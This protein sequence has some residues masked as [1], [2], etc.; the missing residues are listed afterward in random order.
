MELRDNKVKAFVSTNLAGARQAAD[1]S[2]E[3]YRGGAPLS[4][5]DGLPLG[6]KDI[7]ETRDMPTQ[8]GS[9]LF[10]DWQSAG[11]AACITALRE[12][13]A[14]ILGKVVTCEFA[15]AHPSVTTNP[16]DPA[17]TPGGS[18][19][20][21][22]AAV[23]A[24]MVPVA[25]G[26]QALGSITRPA[27]YCGAYGY[28]PSLGAVNRRGCHDHVSQSC[29]GAIGASLADCWTT[30]HAIASRA[31]GAFGHPGLYG[32]E[33]LSPPLRPRRIIR[34]ETAGWQEADPA[35]IDQYEVALER[36][37]ADGIDI[38]GRTNSAPV[39]QFEDL[40]ADAT[41]ITRRVNAW[42]FRWPLTEFCERAADL[43]SPV[44]RQ[45]LA[46]ASQM[47]VDDYRQA[48]ATRDELRRA[49]ADLS[50]SGDVC[51]LLGATGA[52]PLGIEATGNAN[53]NVPASILGT[54]ALSLP[55]LTVD[56][57]PLGLQL[58]GFL[59]GDEALM[60]HARWAEA[61]LRAG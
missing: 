8:M 33:A 56:G 57:L 48:L 61:T 54:P 19:S 37:A 52:A 28:K 43:V 46:D 51:I 23:G 53:I 18:S 9:P 55:L 58:M 1:R 11:D 12:A 13:G 41:A 26:T 21:S 32:A 3:R 31:G 34:L 25:L 35:A 44:M 39:A 10:E 17:R 50:R 6:I 15:A 38:A 47:T 24:G 29:V 2:T 36:L 14:V 60:G 22:G 7:I 49:Y 40:I 16:F 30:V 59:H 27:S 45:R 5:V 42:E 20:G 4:P